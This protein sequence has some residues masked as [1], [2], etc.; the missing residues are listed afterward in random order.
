M[1]FQ[2]HPK[3]ESH[4]LQRWPLKERV[5]HSPPPL[6][7]ALAL[8]LMLPATRLPRSHFFFKHSCFQFQLIH[9]SLF[10]Q[11]CCC[12]QSLLLTDL[13][14]HKLLFLV[15]QFQYHLQFLTTALRPPIGALFCHL[16]GAAHICD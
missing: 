9:L 1:L 12:Q 16:D 5:P 10:L 14:N 8:A 3:S 6:P 13:G 4:L 15:C 2:F 7:F 11:L